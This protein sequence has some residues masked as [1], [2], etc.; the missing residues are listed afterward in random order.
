MFS[1]SAMLMPSRAVAVDHLE[2]LAAR[3]AGGEKVPPEEVMVILDRLHATE[4][5]LQR[6]VDRQARVIEL[7]REAAGGEKV[8]KR[9][10]AIE[11]E[12]ADAEAEVAKARAAYSAALRKHRDEHQAARHRLVAIGQARRALVA[13]ENLPPSQAS[14]MQAARQSCLEA[15]DLRESLTR[16]L[17]VRRVRLRQAEEALPAAEEAAKLH[18]TN[19]GLQAEAERLRNAVASR[20]GLVAEAERS[21][22]D[23]DRRYEAAIAQRD[24]LER[25]VIQKSIR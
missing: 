11:A 12:W 10:A 21:M 25:E 22:A 7:R 5:E 4:D 13:D 1:V 16:E 3:L 17:T 2:E 23:A 20:R 8:E 6:A 18:G 19:D 14:R 24:A 9:I 15:G